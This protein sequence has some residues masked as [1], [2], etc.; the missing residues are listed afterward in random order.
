MPTH[1]TGDE[2]TRR[3]LDAFIKISRARKVLSIQTSQLLAEYGLSES[4]FGAL[5][6]LYYLGPMCQK[7]IGDKLL[8]TG[9]NMTMVINNLEKRQ[10]VSRERAEED[11]RQMVVS[12]TG[13]GQQLIAEL[14]PQ[15]AQNI[16]K[17]MGVL[18]AEQQEQLGQ[19]CKMLGLQ[20]KGS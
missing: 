10:L 13:K 11:R 9:G 14:F 2:T 3:A 5:E 18:D 19:L 6:A 4:Q 7:E 12:L 1:Y 20:T 16:V 15:H 8:V 17:L